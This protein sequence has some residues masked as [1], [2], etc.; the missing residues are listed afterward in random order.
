MS[1][2][3]ASV[4]VDRQ[5]K[6]DPADALESVSLANTRLCRVFH[7]STSASAQR[8][9]LRKGPIFLAAGFIGFLFLSTLWNWAVQSSFPK[10]R[11][12]SAL[13]LIGVVEPPPAPVTLGDLM[14]GGLQRAVSAN[15]GRSLPVFNISVRARNQ[16]LYSVFRAS[17][18][19]GVV[20]GKTD[21]LYGLG[22]IDSFCERSTSPSVEHVNGWASTIRT[23]QDIVESKGKSFA[24]LIT[25][26]KPARYPEYIPPGVFCPALR[27]QEPDRV[28]VFRN[29]LD[30][31]GVRYVDGTAIVE[32]A[33]RDYPIGLF[34]RGGVHWNLLA[35]AL[36][37]R[38]ITSALSSSALGQ[39]EF[40]WSE[41]QQAQGTDRDLL[42]LLN[43]LWPDDHY[44]TAVIR[45]RVGVT[46]C[47]R[48]PR[49]LAIGASFLF[50]VDFAFA[51]A[52]CA[53]DIDDYWYY[54]RP[55]GNG[56]LRRRFHIEK[57]ATNTGESMPG[58]A[59]TELRQ[60]LERAQVV[61][62]EENET[63][64]SNRVEVEDLLRAAKA[65]R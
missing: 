46:P 13:P 44:P 48:V 21:Q 52:A 39:F 54:V 34:A 58:G 56:L 25:P 62:L 23:I 2:N 22:S 20:I 14:S 26:S 5:T 60:S 49:M 18:A 9:F 4:G 64:I 31:H 28:S 61:V 40:D 15:F 33:K 1:S 53:P 27:A 10:L 43:L 35:G 37:A 63:V 24:Y 65:L 8:G 3:D 6:D 59:E 42:D 16:F 19:P 7:F 12:R 55:D 30:K 57:G 50:E 11:I 41:I 45:G 29:A 51:Q 32:K 38:E 47:A 17:G 36:A